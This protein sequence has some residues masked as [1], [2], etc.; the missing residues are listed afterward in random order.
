MLSFGAIIWLY[1]SGGMHD[2]VTGYILMYLQNILF[3][4]LLT[5]VS[6]RHVCMCILD[7]YTM[8]LRLMMTS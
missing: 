2:V 7:M 4:S 8:Y 1:E 5:A 6:L 3:S